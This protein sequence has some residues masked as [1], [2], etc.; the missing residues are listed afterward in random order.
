MRLLAALFVAL[1][2]PLLLTGCGNSCQDL[3]N[4]IC[5]CTGGGTA[6]DTCQR[7]IENQLSDAGVSSG[8]KAFCAARLSA[9]E[10]PAGA[11]FCEWIE[12]QAGK[13]ACGL[14]YQPPASNP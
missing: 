4:R 12:T 2:S 13:E 3:G 11:R 7:Q 1:S 14:A 5:Q 8:D 10:A 9:C 6:R